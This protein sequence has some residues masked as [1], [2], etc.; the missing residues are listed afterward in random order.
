MIWGENE[1][2]N[3]QNNVFEGE[4]TR[5]MNVDTYQQYQETVE[6]D[7]NIIFQLKKRD[8]QLSIDIIIFQI[9]KCHDDMDIPDV[10]EVVY[11]YIYPLL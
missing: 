4:I 8:D 7:A 3:T 1:H 2:K 6:L 5:C 9:K 11:V 10:E